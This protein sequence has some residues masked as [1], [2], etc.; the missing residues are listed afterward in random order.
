MSGDERVLLD[1]AR[2]ALERYV[3][4]SVDPDGSL[5]FVH[6]GVPCAVQ[7]VTLAQ[8]LTVLSTTCVLVWDVPAGPEGYELVARL[9]AEVQFG[10]LGVVESGGTVDVTLRYAFPAAG[11][12]PEPL[13][14]LLLLVVSGASRARVQLLNGSQ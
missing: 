4:V 3:D 12:A 1:S 13:A 5:S 11:L 10:G 6:S 8:G 9:G 2:G 14:T 7:A